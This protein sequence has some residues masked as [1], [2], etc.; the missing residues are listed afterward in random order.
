[1]TFEQYN[2]KIRAKIEAVNDK[3]PDIL[4]SWDSF[5][6]PFNRGYYESGFTIADAVTD[7]IATSD[8][9]TD[10]DRAIAIH[11]ELTKKYEH[12]KTLDSADDSWDHNITVDGNSP[13]D[14]LTI[15]QINGWQASPNLLRLE[16]VEFR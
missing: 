16:Q 13:P 9:Y 10:A 2:E 12:K 7:I 15:E 4:E 6:T 14:T 11:H 8:H 5:Q 3:Y 1:M